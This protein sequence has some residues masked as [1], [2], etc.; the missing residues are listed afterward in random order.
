MKHRTILPVLLAAALLFGAAPGALPNE[1]PPILVNVTWDGTPGALV[2]RL[3]AGG[4]LPNRQRLVASGV[5]VSRTVGNWP[6]ITPAGHAA[7]W[8]GAY[9]SVNG[10]STSIP[11]VL[12]G[13][14]GDDT[15]GQAMYGPVDAYGP[16]P[17]SAENL[18]VEPI[19][20]TAARDG[21]STTAVSVTNASPF[22]MYTSDNYVSTQGAQAFGDFSDQLLLSDP[23]RTVGLPPVPASVS[24]SVTAASD[25]ENLPASPD[26]SF[27]S[28]TLGDTPSGADEDLVPHGLAVAPDGEVFT[29]VALSPNRDYETAEILRVTP[30]ADNASQLSGPVR[31]T[32]CDEEDNCVTGYAH[33][34]LTDLTGD[35]SDLTLWRTYLRDLSEYTTN[36]SRI[37]EWIANG[38]A[39][40]GNGATLPSID[41]L[42]KLPNIYGEIAFQVNEYFFDNLT[43]EI[44]RDS[45]DLYFSYSPYPDEWMHRLYGYTVL[46]TLR[47]GRRWPPATSTR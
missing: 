8:T 20:V 41:Q 36:P 32:D 12:T 5:H 7:L 23:Y 17:F 19:W 22:E 4:R 21:L 11:D 34:R 43:Y 39:F 38:G 37:S 1:R 10:I 47:S 42:S 31:Y 15:N 9:S 14:E 40:T 13:E 16:S 24:P 27:R 30:F 26:A 35:G 6:S 44:E 33:F 45:A 2:E 25:W 29:H 18:L 3:L 28:F 46:S